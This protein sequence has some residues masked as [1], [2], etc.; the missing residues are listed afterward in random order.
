MSSCISFFCKEILAL[1]RESALVFFYFLIALVVFDC[2]GSFLIIQKVSYTEIDWI[3]YM[4]E[5][6]GFLGGEYNYYN[7]KGDTGPLVYPAGFVYIYSALFYLTNEG[8]DIRLAQYIF[9]GVYIATLVAVLIIYSKAGGLPCWALV[10]LLASK[11]IHSI[12]MLR[13]FND[14]VAM[15]LLYLAVLLFIHN[16][17]RAGCVLYSVAVSVKMNIL[18]F[19]P[20][21]LLLLLQSQGVFG[22]IPCLAVCAVVQVALGL[23]FLLRYPVA[24]VHRSFELGRVFLFKWTVNFKFLDE[25]VFT[26][27]MLSFVLLTF[28][29]LTLAV[30]AVKW[31]SSTNCMV[32]FQ[33][34]DS[35]K[36]LTPYYTTLTLFVSN[37]IGVVF[38]R[39]L[40]YQFYCW[41]FHALPF[42]V[43]HC[44]MSLW[45][46]LSILIS[47]EFAFNKY[48]A[49][50]ESS[51]ILQ[52]SHILL[53][54]ALWMSP[55][56]NAMHKQ[57][58]TRKDK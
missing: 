36:K 38:A 24:Y 51:M 50:P 29:V 47:I 30:F 34:N 13:C 7:L 9:M 44:R 55:L 57:N 39:S 46:R 15:L 58:L 28:M 20:G 54:G 14:G 2:L 43:W 16:R 23:P 49:S 48:P 26:S 11:R 25:Q 17:W 56:Q 21:L 6:K 45:I 19:A 32:G 1:Q 27:K 35:S 41:Y 33:Y 40:H 18:L 12:Y 3:A 53:L 5:V 8:E 31:L 42:L 22:A 4:Q 52:L 10:L 37:F